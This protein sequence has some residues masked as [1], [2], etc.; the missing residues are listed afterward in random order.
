MYINGWFIVTAVSIFCIISET[1]LLAIFL[2]RPSW[3]PPTLCTSPHPTT[4]GN[5]DDNLDVYQEVVQSPY[6]LIPGNP[7]SYSQSEPPK[8]IGALR[9]DRKNPYRI[10]V[11]IH[12]LQ[13]GNYGL[14]IEKVD[15][16]INKVVQIPRP[17]NVWVTTQVPFMRC[18]PRSVLAPHTTSQPF[19]LSLAASDIFATRLP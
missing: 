16:V 11:G 8:Q 4:R 14:L 7:A 19:I 12:S 2:A 9:L 10:V 3:C 1:S 17:L 15:I 6:F 18:K 5:H 13:Q